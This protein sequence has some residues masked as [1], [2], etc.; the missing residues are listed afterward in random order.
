MP[1]SRRLLAF[2]L[3]E[4]IAL[5]LLP[6]VTAIKA[7]GPP[8][9]PLNTLEMLQRDVISWYVAVVFALS[10]LALVGKAGQWYFGSENKLR[11]KAVLNTLD[12][13]CFK[14]QPA[15]ERYYNRVTLF[16]ANRRKTKLLPYC[17]AGDQY[18]RGIGPFAIHDNNQEANEGI[19]GQAWF[20]AV[21]VTVN[22]LPVVPD[23]REEW[24]VANGAC[25]EYARAG[26]LSHEKAARLRVKS[27]N[28]L[29]T[30]VR[31]FLGN[32]WGVLVMDCRNP[33]ILN[34]QAKQLAESTARVLGQML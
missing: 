2:K 13:G 22:D 9:Q 10:M 17:R 12:E 14:D 15:D 29:A 16:K 21:T 19:S 11:V 7:A 18:Q 6:V 33:G 26:F 24:S 32:K 27:R 20:R 5:A 3:A 34:A 8:E 30:P 25:K 31:D 28:I 23:R 1:G 4:W